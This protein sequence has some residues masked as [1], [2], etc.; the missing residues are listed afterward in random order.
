MD[1]NQTVR[2]YTR[3]FTQYIL[4]IVSKQQMW[5]NSLKF[6]VYLFKDACSCTLN[7]QE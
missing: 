1:L 2:I 6:N 5:F 4:Q 7:I 3:E